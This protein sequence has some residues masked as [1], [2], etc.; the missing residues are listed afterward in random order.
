MRY[1]W[2]KLAQPFW[3][4]F[5]LKIKTLSQ[6]IHFFK[7]IIGAALSNFCQAV[8]PK[9][10]VLQ[11]SFLYFL[12]AQI[13]LFHMILS[14]YLSDFFYRNGIQKDNFLTILPFKIHTFF[15]HLIDSFCSKIWL[16]HPILTNN[17]SKCRPDIK[18]LRKKIWT[19][20]RTTVQELFQF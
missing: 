12:K 18:E 3:I 5:N 9:I 1:V 17:H 11:S 16:G 6:R 7:K 4:C 14:M 13:L 19:E 8:S 15:F 2:K 20:I 10:Q